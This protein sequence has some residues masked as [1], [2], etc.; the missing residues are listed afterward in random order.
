MFDF[1]YRHVSGSD[2]D[3]STSSA[4][5]SDDVVIVSVESGSRYVQ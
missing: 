1:V 3:L 2:I 5:D 4:S